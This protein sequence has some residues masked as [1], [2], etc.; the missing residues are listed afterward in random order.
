MDLGYFKRWQSWEDTEIATL[1]E[2]SKRK[3][4]VIIDCVLNMID[5]KWAKASVYMEKGSLELGYFYHDL[6]HKNTHNTDKLQ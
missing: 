1:K 3:V 2:N 4:L 6:K 5:C